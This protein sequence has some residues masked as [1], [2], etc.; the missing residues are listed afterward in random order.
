MSEVRDIVAMVDAFLAEI[1]H[2]SLIDADKVRD[3]LLDFRLAL[4]A[5]HSYEDGL[6]DGA[7][8]G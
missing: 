7:A 3:A 6:I 2:L 5:S 4:A 1:R 8:S